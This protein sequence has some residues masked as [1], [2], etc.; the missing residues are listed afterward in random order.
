MTSWELL[1]YNSLSNSDIVDLE[2]LQLASILGY[3]VLFMPAV[4]LS[5]R[6]GESFSSQGWNRLLQVAYARKPISL[7]LD[8]NH[9][10]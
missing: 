8:S 2:I 9:K 3:P 7:M 4:D 5:R 10:H 1:K 6:G